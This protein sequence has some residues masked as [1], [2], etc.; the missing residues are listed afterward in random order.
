MSARFVA[1]VGLLVAGAAAAQIAMR[2]FD[3][4]VKKLPVP[5]KK[6][7]HLAD[8]AA[9]RPRYEL[10]GQQ[11]PPPS[12][13]M[14][15]TLGTHE[16]LNWR[17]V[18]REKSASDKTRLAE[19]VVTYHTGGHELVPHVPEE[20]MS[21]GGYE[22][23]Q[24]PD[25]LPVKVPGVGAAND[26]FDVRVARFHAPG[27]QVA[28][29]GSRDSEV[30]IL[31][32]FHSNGTYCTTRREVRVQLG[33]LNEKYSYYMKVELKFTDETSRSSASAEDSLRAAEPLL[34]RLLPVLFA[35]HLQWEN[36]DKLAGP[37]PASQG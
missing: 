7:L 15:A 11:P 36:R 13:E 8:A 23:I 34:E 30:A 5:L 21:A 37:A 32:F 35:E 25:D 28:V 9:L 27:G 17:L 33:K 4:N 10:F 3:L 6:P 26:K 2:A 1:C 20:C 31:Y 12:E 16:F 14:F 22:M 18:D 29:D 19:V 24:Q